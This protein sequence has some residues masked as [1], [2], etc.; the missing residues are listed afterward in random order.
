MVAQKNPEYY[1][2]EYHGK[3]FT[4]D[5]IQAILERKGMPGEGWKTKMP[6]HLAHYIEAQ[7]WD[8]ELLQCFARQVRTGGV[9]GHEA[10]HAGRPGS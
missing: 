10:G 7:V 8:H 5:E 9:D 1:E 4:L 3:V 2:P 6:A